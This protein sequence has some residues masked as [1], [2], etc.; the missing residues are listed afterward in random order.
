MVR[1]DIPSHTLHRLETTFLL[2]NEGMFFFFVCFFVIELF[3][4]RLS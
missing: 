3:I 4:S 1:C 2:K